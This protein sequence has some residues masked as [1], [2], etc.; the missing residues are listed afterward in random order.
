MVLTK[1]LDYGAMLYKS[2]NF[3]SLQ[4]LC[5]QAGWITICPFGN[6]FNALVVDKIGR[7]KM[8]S[9]SRFLVFVSFEI[10]LC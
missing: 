4:Q 5:L 8:I 1:S 10:F 7:V 3:N 9:K 6:L 2:L